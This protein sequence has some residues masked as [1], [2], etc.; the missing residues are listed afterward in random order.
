M[1]TNTID[2]N[3]VYTM[4]FLAN[5]VTTQSVYS[6]Q[7]NGFPLHFALTLIS[8]FL[9]SKVIFLLKIISN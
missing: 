7:S 5:D 1:V 3:N 9:L 4:H 8:L 2:V 6:I